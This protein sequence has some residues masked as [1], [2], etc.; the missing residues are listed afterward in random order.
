MP[1][2]VAGPIHALT[3]QLLAKGI[4][5]LT[6]DTSEVFN[7]GTTKLMAKHVHIKMGV[8]KSNGFALPAILDLA[9]WNGLNYVESIASVVSHLE[10]TN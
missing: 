7:V 2:K 9:L 6:I 1:N 8:S 5:E 3:L 4:I 10:T